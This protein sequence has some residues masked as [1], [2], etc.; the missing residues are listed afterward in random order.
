MWNQRF[1]TENYIYGT[2]PNDFLKSIEIPSNVKNAI[3]L[4]EGEGR[5]AVHLAKKGIDV[6]ALDYSEVGLEKTTKLAKTNNVTVKTILADMREYQLPEN[7][8]DA[9]ILIFGHFTNDVKQ[10]VFAQ[11]RKTLKKDGIF[12]MEAYAT[13]QIN[14]DSGGPKN[15]E[16]L[17]SLEEIISYLNNEFQIVIKQLIYRDIQEGVMHC[18]K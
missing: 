8:F 10:N 6:Y 1:D 5:N 18:G 7:N 17:Y 12:I 16:L 2:A 11:I 13:E 9:V 4:A 14:M 15:P 3:C